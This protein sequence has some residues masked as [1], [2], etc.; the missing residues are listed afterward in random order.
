MESDKPI[1]T[2][3]LREYLRQSPVI[4]AIR[5][6]GGDTIELTTPLLEEFNKLV[7]WEVF[8]R[9]G[10]D[11]WIKHGIAQDLDLRW[12]HI[13]IIHRIEPGEA[14]PN[15]VTSPTDDDG[16]EWWASPEEACAWY[17]EEERER[18]AYLLGSSPVYADLSADQLLEDL[19]EHLLDEAPEDWTESEIMGKLNGVQELRA[20]IAAFNE[21]N[22]DNAIYYTADRSV[23]VYL[24]RRA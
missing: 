8:E 17:D 11:Y 6:T 14:Y 21:A 22:A 15:Q 12:Y 5:G 23:R 10:K 1:T 16:T 2:V 4:A 3:L 24:P 19:A 20:A 18:P 9:V 7:A 13:R